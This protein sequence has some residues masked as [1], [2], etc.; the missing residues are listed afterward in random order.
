MTR[1]KYKLLCIL[2]I[3]T[4][5]A[6]LNA[7]NFDTKN[8][9][10]IG[11]GAGLVSGILNQVL[12]DD[13]LKYS[14]TNT[15]VYTIA[16]DR[17]INNWLQLGA[18]FTQQSM[19]VNFEEYADNEGILQTG[20]FEANLQRRQIHVRAFGY[21]EVNRFRFR[22]GLRFGLGRWKAD[23]NTE[24]KELKFIDRLAGLTLPSLGIMI[25]GLDY[26]P[27][28]WMSLGTEVNLLSPQLVG[29]NVQIHF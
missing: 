10:A 22:S 15:P 3:G 25:I 23:V 2:T 12:K 13:A 11:T 21:Y 7:Q 14:F 6:E 5:G 18:N 17:R 4:M 19:T 27:T 16:Y 8:E 28:K 1:W 26:R 24:N 29:A 20:D 9:L